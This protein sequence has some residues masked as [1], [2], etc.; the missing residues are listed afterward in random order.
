MLIAAQRVI[1]VIILTNQECILRLVIRTHSP[2]TRESVS[3]DKVVPILHL[4]DRADG[5]FPNSEIVS[6]CLQV[7]YIPNKANPY[8]MVMCKYQQQQYTFFTH[9]I[10]YSREI[11]S[12]PFNSVAVTGTLCDYLHLSFSCHD[13]PKLELLFCSMTV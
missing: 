9:F 5:A 7:K 8:Q 4:P 11:T 10:C 6:P 3:L 13:Q 12:D 2:T 1:G